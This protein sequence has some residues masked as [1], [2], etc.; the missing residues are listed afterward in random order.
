MIETADVDLQ[1]PRQDY[2]YSYDSSRVETFGFGTTVSTVRA[3]IAPFRFG[4][5]A[6]DVVGELE[7]KTEDRVLEIGSGLGLL[8]RAI[9]DRT[10]G[11]IQYYGVELALNPAL[12]SKEN[13]ITPLQADA[14]R[15]PFASDSFDAVIT[16]DVLEHIPDARS[17]VQE[18]KRVMKPGGK[19]F[20]V[21][22]DPS[23]G[24]FGN[25]S[26]HLDRTGGGTDVGFWQRLFEENSLRL[27]RE[28]S[29]KYRRRDWRRIFNFPF[30]VKLKDKPGFACAF[31]PVNRP[32]TYILEK[33]LEA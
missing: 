20:V 27:M 9:K 22:A 14:V 11:D 21:I 19:A 7:I 15:L 8:G 25:V 33:P 17:A 2:R 30:L 26:G 18:I 6:K 24:R 23:E 5:A 12:R 4:L 1:R 3:K 13:A 10:R 31:N 32:G 16:T 28:E 29:R